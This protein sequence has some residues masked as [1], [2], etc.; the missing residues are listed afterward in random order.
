MTAFVIFNYL[1]VHDEQKI[2]AYRQRAHPIVAQHGGHVRVRPG[3]LEVREGVASQYLIVT[4]FDDMETARRWYDS[5]E[6]QLAR[7]I[8]EG[9]ADVQVIMTECLPE[10]GTA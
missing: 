2:L 3:A 9:A 10:D 5:E 6:Y 7:K 4:E 8:R 1:Q